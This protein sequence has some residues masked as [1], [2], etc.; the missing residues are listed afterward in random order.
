M[1]PKVARFTAAALLA[2][3]ILMAVVFAIT[4]N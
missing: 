2:A 1:R 3:V 4:Q